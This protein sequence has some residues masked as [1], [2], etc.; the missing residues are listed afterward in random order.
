MSR[1]IGAG[2]AAAVL[3]G[4]YLVVSGAGLL[5]NLF[6]REVDKRMARTRQRA[7]ARG[8]IARGKGTT[9][10]L[11]LVGAGLLVLGIW[12]G[13]ESVALAVAGVLYYSVLYTLVLKPKFALST[14]PGSVAGVFPS[15][16]ACSAGGTPWSLR[17]LF[18]CLFILVWS[19]AHFW[20]LA[21]ARREDYAR[22]GIPT[23]V[24]QYGERATSILVFATVV[25]LTILSAL[26]TVVRLAG[27][28]YLGIVLAAGAGMMVLAAGPL[29]FGAASWTWA[30]HKLSGPYL[31]V[32][33]VALAVSRLGV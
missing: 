1:G 21:L 6:D 13:L 33:L 8:V 7:T 29:F 25:L 19:P 11:V 27:F 16:I 31:G 15:L 4:V 20:A 3:V 22:A 26:P 5:N 12:A 18:L 14:L 23:P 10:A 30:V 28:V 9:A 2:E 17:V 32:V 24:Q